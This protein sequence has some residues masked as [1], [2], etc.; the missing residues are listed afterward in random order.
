MTTFSPR[1]AAG[2]S[3]IV[4]ATA[5][6]PLQL[7]PITDP[8]NPTVSGVLNNASRGELQNL[9]TGL[10]A[11]SRGGL[12]ATIQVFGT[13]ARELWYLN[14]DARYF[15]DMLGQ[16]VAVYPD[17]FGTGGTYGTPYQAIKQGNVLLEAVANTSTINAQEASAYAGFTKT[18]QALQ[19]LIPLNAQYENGIRIDVK[20]PLNP[21]PFL[22]YPEALAAIRSL[23]DQAAADL[24]AAGTALPF[25]L[26]S[27]WD[28]FT[29]PAGV[30]QVNRAIAARAAIY[31]KD[32]QG[33][34][35]A[36][37]GSFYAAE[38]NLATGP[39]AV[40]SN[41]PDIFN[42][43]YF[44]L[45]TSAVPLIVVHPTVTT[46]AI[47]GDIRVGAKFAARTTP[48]VNPR[49]VAAATHQPTIWPTPTSP[50]PYIRNEELVLIHAEAHAQLGNTEAAVASI[51]RIRLAA[52]LA[53]YTGTTTLD[54]LIT[55]VLLQRK[56]ALWGEGH[57]WIDLRRYDRLEE[58]P[59]AEDG[60]T[61]FRQL[62]RPASETQWDDQAGQ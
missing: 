27:G 3:L 12:V 4:V 45:N 17:H 52:G 48:Y 31:A 54:A 41:P 8:N 6:N 11:R 39:K 44:P 58:V 13:F 23:L 9:L 60:G 7:D 46:T 22:S 24:D 2:L 57:R 19:Y 25:R 16:G 59:L 10:E 30:R 20:D 36:L 55:E 1:L 50:I 21:G 18:M 53:R 34:L 28:G 56:Y 62:V 37:Q 32:W 43:L 29:T 42:P 26:S 49:L 47:P 14:T 15:T 51:D 61:V 5:C 33:A 38:G 40:F 35:T